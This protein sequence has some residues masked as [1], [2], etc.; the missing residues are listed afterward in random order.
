MS[1]L[2]PAWQVAERD[3]KL[4]IV[5][6]FEVTLLSRTILRAEFLVRHFGAKNGMLVFTDYRLVRPYDEELV[7]LGYGYSVMDRDNESYVREDF[8]DVLSDWG[9][10]GDKARKPIWLKPHPLSKKL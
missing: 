7:N 8:I 9:W 3:L 10:S 6:P 2:W 4:E 1:D 5:A